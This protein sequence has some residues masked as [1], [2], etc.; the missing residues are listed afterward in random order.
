[1]GVSR[2]VEGKLH[3]GRRIVEKVIFP[4]VLLIYP[5]LLIHQGIDVS[6]T[7]YSLGYYRFMGEMDMTW[8]LATYLANVAGAFL[9]KLPMGNTLLG[10]NFYT[11]LLVSAIALVCYYALSR[12]MP[13]LIVFLGEVTAL[14]LCW[15]PTTILYNYL[16]YFFFAAG[17]VCPVSY[18]H[19][20]LPTIGG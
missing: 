8:V 2:A 10:M 14:S 3:T 13:S 7:T 11:G 12:W 9:L 18:T 17:A 19:L 4:A 6:D 20:T 1:M 16:T 15:C 5:L